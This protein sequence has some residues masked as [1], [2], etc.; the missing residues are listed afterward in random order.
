M[1]FLKNLF[2]KV[3][4]YVKLLP[5]LQYVGLQVSMIPGLSHLKADAAALASF[6]CFLPSVSALGPNDPKRRIALATVG[7]PLLIVANLTN[8]PGYQ[9][10]G[11]S[12]AMTS[13]VYTL[14]YP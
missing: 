3:S 4:E 6:V 8:H 1:A 9:F 7:Y 11:F 13:F 10:V 12:L 5:W 14:I 2:S